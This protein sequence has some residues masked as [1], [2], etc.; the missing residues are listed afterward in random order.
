MNR[1]NEI[2]ESSHGFNDKAECKAQRHAG[3]CLFKISAYVVQRHL[4]LFKL[5]SIERKSSEVTAMSSVQNRISR[6]RSIAFKINLALTLVFSIVMLALMLY[7]YQ[8]DRSRNLQQGLEHVRGMNHFYFDSLNTLM[9][10]DAMEERE[11]LRNKLL[12]LPGIL[13]VRVIRGDAVNQRFGQGFNHEQP[14]DELDFQAL[15]GESIERIDTRDEERVI[16]L[17]EPYFLTENTR[18]TDC[19]ECHRRVESGTMG[20]VIRMEYSLAE[21]DELALNELVKKLAGMLFLF[22][23]GLVGLSFLLKYLV[24]DRLQVLQDRIRDIAAGEGDLTHTLDESSSDE[25]GQVAHWFNVFVGRMRDTLS[26]VHTY[27]SQLTL[28][29]RDMNQVAHSTSSSVQDQHSQTENITA[30]MSDMREKVEEVSEHAAEAAGAAEQA[31]QE[32]LQG[33]TVVDETI[34]SINRLAG[35]VDKAGQVIQQVEHDS[36]KINMVLDVIRGIA[37]QTNLLALNAAIEAARAGE[38][39]RGFAVVADEVRNLAEKTQQSTQEIQQMIESL[40]EGAKGAVVVMQEGRRQAEN[41]V[42][43][44]ARAGASLGSINGVVNNI[45]DMNNRISLVAGQHSSLSTQMSNNLGKISEIA[46][47]TSRDSQQLAKSSEMLTEMATKLREKLEF[48][49]V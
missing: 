21:V 3:F 37:E 27:T 33:K 12:E 43:Q 34:E 35:E 11:E 5:Q 4:K 18:G 23:L 1:I 36:D 49:K 41:S 22:V 39:G 17:L 24:I 44:A 46:A 48:F 47:N 19:L 25:L 9:L 38:Q 28:Q 15:K 8:S 14:V 29:L 32:A 10:G 42:E 30:S 13:D 2:F 7:T 16:T 45:S 31:D 6:R 40:Q 26:E 20:G